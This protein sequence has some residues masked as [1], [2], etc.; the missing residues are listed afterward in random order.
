M[1]VWT[2]EAASISSLH[3]VLAVAT[4]SLPDALPPPAPP[5]PV[6]SPSPASPCVLS[7]AKLSP[8]SELSL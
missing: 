7:S 6:A 1:K 5:H 2:R 8:Y 4:D 3:D